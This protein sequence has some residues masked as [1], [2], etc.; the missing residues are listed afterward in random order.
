MLRASMCAMNRSDIA[1][2]GAAGAPSPL[3]HEQ[4]RAV[5]HGGRAAHANGLA[6]QAAFAEELARAEHAHDGFPAR[7]GQHRQ[8]DA[9]LLDV[10]HVLARVALGEEDDVAS[11]ILD[12]LLRDPSRVKEDFALK[13]PCCFDFI[14]RPLNGHR[15]RG[16]ERRRL[17]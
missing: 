13:V 16:S 7:L 15:T 4:D 17:R 9:A 14:G 11:P 3:V 8:L 5:G 1:C 12:D 2:C 10:E 6:G